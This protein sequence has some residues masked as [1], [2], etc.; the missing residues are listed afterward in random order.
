MQ[1]FD[2]HCPENNVLKNSIRPLIKMGMSLLEITPH[3]F[4][5]VCNSTRLS[6][7]AQEIETWFQSVNEMMSPWFASMPW[8]F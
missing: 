7:R 6:K 2:F 5:I 8:K 3:V 4:Q 1:H